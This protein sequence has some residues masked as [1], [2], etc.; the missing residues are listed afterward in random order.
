M[1]SQRS[2][3]ALDERAREQALDAIEREL[4]DR[5]L[6]APLQLGDADE[7][8]W[9][10]CD[11]AS[12]AE[13]RLGDPTSPD[14]LTPARREQWLARA[15][16]EPPWSPSDRSEHERLRWLTSQGQ[17][18]GTLA[19]SAGWGHASSIRAASLYVLPSHRRQG[20]AGTVLRALR[21]GLRRDGL[22]LR[23]DTSWTWQ[24]VVHMYL[25]MGVWVHMWKREL[26][27]RLDAS[28]PA[29]IFDFEG[30]R[31]TMEVELDGVRVALQRAH[32]Y[33]DRLVLEE[34]PSSEHPRVEALR[35]ASASTFA[36]ALA[37]QGWPLVRSQEDWDDDHYADAGPPEAL[38]SRIVQWEAWSHARG[39]KVDTPRIPGLCYPTWT[40]LEA[41]WA[42]EN[43]EFEQRS[44]KAQEQP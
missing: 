21:D 27:L 8:A 4:F 36:L 30:D 6:L 41:R 31:A 43:A 2:P 12:L 37:L 34:R 32:R 39:W 19:L 11:L 1:P 14:E 25:R 5:D 7:R 23:L 28:M 35:L 33:G 42:R 10:D 15:T 16:T 9:M 40:E 24:P 13:N 26:G 22:F 18:V 29:P 38:A 17:R 44:K 20:T 3:M